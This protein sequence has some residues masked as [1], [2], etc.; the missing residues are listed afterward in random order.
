MRIRAG[1]ALVGGGGDG[2]TPRGVG[3][4]R[5]SYRGAEVVILGGRRCDSAFFR[6]GGIQW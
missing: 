2:G 1:A 6:D 5:C 3:I 4:R